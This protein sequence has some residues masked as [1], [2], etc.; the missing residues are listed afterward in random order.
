MNIVERFKHVMHVLN[1]YFLQ[2]VLSFSALFFFYADS[3]CV[4]VHHWWHIR[5]LIW[6]GLTCLQ[7]V[8]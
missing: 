3:S 7:A 8:C 1:S 6:N 2:R 4:Y 5:L